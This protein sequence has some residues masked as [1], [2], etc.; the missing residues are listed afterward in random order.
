M[1]KTNTRTNT[2]HSGTTTHSG[3]EN[4]QSNT[5]LGTSTN[6]SQQSTTT[7]ENRGTGPGNKWNWEKLETI[8]SDIPQKLVIS[9][10]NWFLLVLLLYGFLGF[11]TMGIQFSQWSYTPHCS[12]LYY[13]LGQTF[14]NI[15]SNLSCGLAFIGTRSV[16]I[17]NRGRRMSKT[18]L[19]KSPNG[20]ILSL[21]DSG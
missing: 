8:M 17:T 19:W 11:P 10:D 13:L 6:G 2:G 14:C 16:K 20:R 1:A 4:S 12:A 5:N 3:N 9:I 18:L 15:P 7:I 21:G